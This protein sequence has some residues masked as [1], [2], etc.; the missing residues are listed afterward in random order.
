[1]PGNG[2]DD[3]AASLGDERMAG[4]LF[5]TKTSSIRT[6]KTLKKP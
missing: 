2:E 4:V 1:M 3:M 6:S 5:R